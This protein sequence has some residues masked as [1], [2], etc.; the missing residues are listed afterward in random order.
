MTRPRQLPS[1]DPCFRGRRTALAAMDAFL[2][3]W[4]TTSAP[5]VIAIQGM[6]GVGKTALAVH[7]AH[8][9][10]DRFPDGQLF[11]DLR[12]HSVDAEMDPCEA[13]DRLLRGLGVP[14][15][16]V[17]AELDA[18]VALVRSHFAQRSMLLILDNAAGSEQVYPLLASGRRCA[19]IVTSR[20]RLPSLIVSN[21]AHTLD[22]D[23][24]SPDEAHELVAALL[25]PGEASA[26]RDAVEGL[27]R[28]CACLPLAL[29]IAAANQRVRPHATVA[30]VV[31]EL[32]DG[33]RLSAL[34]LDDDP[35][36]SAVR[37]AF[38]LSYRQL[39]DEQR[40]GFRL[41][42]LIPGPDFGADAV[43]ALLD[44][45][46]AATQ[47]IL[48]GLTLANLVEQ[49]GPRRYRL[50]DLI[51]DYARECLKEGE[52]LPE[53]TAAHRRLLDWLLETAQNAAQDLRPHPR[54]DPDGGFNA[55]R[56]A[57]DWYERER[58]LLVAGT[59]QAALSGFRRTTWQLAET[60]FGF[61]DL[62]AYTQDNLEVHQYGAEAAAQA[63]DD[64]ALAM[65]LRHLACV[66]REQGR[67]GKAVKVGERALELVAGHGDPRVEAECMA[68]LAGVY[69]RCS[70]YGQ[71][72][73]LIHGALLIRQRLADRRGEAECLHDLARIHRRLGHCVDALRCDLEAL[74]IRQEI[75]DRYGEARSLL[76]LSRVFCRM[77]LRDRALLAAEDALAMFEQLGAQ[78]GRG[79]TLGSIANILRHLGRPSE[80]LHSGN[81]A[82]AVQTAIGDSRG[83]T[84]TR[85]N[86]ARVHLA[87]GEVDQA[88]A[89][90]RLALSIDRQLSDPYAIALRRHTLGLINTRLERHREALDDFT[91]ELALREE[92][93]DVRG[94]A[95][96]YI[97]MA[98]LYDRMGD[99]AR[100]VEYAERAVTVERGFDNPF[101]LGRRLASA[102]SLVAR[103]RGEVAARPYRTEARRLLA[104]FDG[105]GA[106]DLARRPRSA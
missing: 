102:G 62:R 44:R 12:G 39:A 27:I 95:T 7:W 97:A 71:V 80:A 87:L 10:A 38:G 104:D 15:E 92:I 73:R 33:D 48:R 101:S 22:L 45:D 67:Y 34:A 84:A 26:Q 52:P 65:M 70:D 19:T 32:G 81:A 61:L 11:V 51:A 40:R 85:D 31:R 74:D 24:L 68:T 57:L 42:G 13:L 5:L 1:D 46:H 56:D 3:G 82:L 103:H 20:N 91:A 18:Q 36:R 72:R 64:R 66:Y 105:W 59:R 98:A 28:Q 2:A 90:A 4:A 89:H 21:G 76:S 9:V 83:E 58:Q 99:G 49:T 25:A 93:G 86:L 88:L 29:R 100:T 55:L 79:L 77:G 17:P 63:G 78:Q 23:V 50:H 30:D 41:L 43:A 8:A 75:G 6:P 47:Q 37:T 14:G 35:R 106:A 69:W 54:P 96:T 94:T 60:L 16:L 53:R